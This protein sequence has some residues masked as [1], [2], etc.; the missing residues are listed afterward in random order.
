[1]GVITQ[2]FLQEIM[3]AYE[4]SQVTVKIMDRTQKMSHEE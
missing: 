3:T 2:K 1:M 4:K